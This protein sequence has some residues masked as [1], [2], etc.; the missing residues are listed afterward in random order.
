M[1]KTYL[2]LASALMMGFASCDTARQTQDDETRI[3]ATATASGPTPT[4]AVMSK[5]GLR[6][7]AFDDSQKY[8]DSQLRLN[9]PP[10]NGVVQPGPVEFVYD[11]TN[12]Q[13]TRMTPHSNAEFMANSQEGQHIHHIVDNEPYTAHYE[14]SFT[15][16]ME[17]GHHVVLSFLSRS[18]HESLKHRG[19]Y[20]LR[21]ITVGRPQ[22]QM[23]F[24]MKGQHM[25]YSRPKGEYVGSDTRRIMLDFYL[26]NTEL[27]TAGNKVRA[28]INGNEFILDKWMPH[29]IEGLP[30]GENTIKLE[31]INN[32]GAVVPGPYNSVTRTIT[33]RES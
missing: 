22:Q 14:T 29:I 16:E 32:A 10:A 13:L 33:L 8:P 28:T 15:K 30:M 4:G 1:K 12:F 2:L 11:L 23:E 21:M 25:F 19:A 27:S 31:L 17:E 6:V 24:D 7:F 20:D 26:V 18:Y 5:G 9:T 3:P